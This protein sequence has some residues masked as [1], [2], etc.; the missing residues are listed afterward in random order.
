MFRAAEELIAEAMADTPDL[1]SPAIRP[2]MSQEVEEQVRDAMVQYKNRRLWKRWGLHKVRKQGAAVLLHG[3][4]GT[5]KDTIA[6]WM[7]K[8]INRGCLV[9]DISKVGGGDPGQSERGVHEL[10]ANGRNR[11]G[12][13][14]LMNECQSILGNRLEASDDTWMVSTT[15]AIMMEMDT[16]PGL[17]IGITNFPVK[18]DRGLKRRFMSV[19]KIDEPD[20]EMRK[21]L[22]RQKVPT[23]FPLQLSDEQLETITDSELNGSQIENVIVSVGSHCIR[24]G[25]K[26]KLAHFDRFIKA[27]KRKSLG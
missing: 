26:P 10:F 1:L 6:N 27:E 23:E 22:W 14:I 5:G 13:T 2:I 19:I 21:R 18:M 25:I 9:L 15:E 17:V 24:K 12:M 11:N 7:A 4:P 20:K 8:Q 3:P 16:Y